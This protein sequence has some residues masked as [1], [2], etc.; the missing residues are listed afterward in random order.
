M[1]R[2][3]AV[4]PVDCGLVAASGASGAAAPITSSISSAGARSSISSALQGGKDPALVA[5]NGLLAAAV[6][7]ACSRLPEIS[8]LA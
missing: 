5:S 8:G 3:P 4:E 1:V 7:I 2:W 6:S